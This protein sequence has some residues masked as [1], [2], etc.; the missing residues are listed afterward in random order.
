MWFYPETSILIKSTMHIAFP[1]LF[2]QSL[3]TSPPTSAKF[4]NFPLFSLNLSFCLLNLHFFASPYFDHDAFMP[5]ILRLKFEDF[6]LN[7]L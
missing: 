1:P 5:V 4:I 3:Y 7:L 2:L 6:G